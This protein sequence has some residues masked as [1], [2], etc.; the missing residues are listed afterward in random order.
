MKKKYLISVYKDKYFRD[1]IAYLQ[2]PK[3]YF[4]CPFS[5]SISIQ[6]KKKGD[7]KKTTI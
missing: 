4:Q 5:F 1:Y 3:Y 2:F 7:R 6:A